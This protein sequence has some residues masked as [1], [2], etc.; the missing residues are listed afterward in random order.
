MPR[1]VYAGALAFL[2]RSGIP[3]VRLLGGEPTEHPDFGD[4]VSLALEGGFAVTVFTSGLI[5]DTALASLRAT[6]PGRVAVVMNVAVPK[7]DPNEW[8]TAQARVCR[9]L[10]AR[11]ELGL[12][13]APGA[14]DPSFLL[15][16]IEERGLRR[17]IRLGLA[18]P[19]LGAQ[20]AHLR[21]RSLRN[22]SR[23]LEPFVAQAIE[24]GV[25]VDFDCGFTCCMFSPHF[26]EDHPQ[27]A[28]DIGV[29]CNPIIDLL[30][31][32]KAIACYA[33][34]RWRHLP[35]DNRSTCDGL[36]R[37]FEQD[38]ED[39]L[40]VGM[41]PECATCAH[42]AEGRCNGGCRARRFRRL[43]PEPFQMP[44]PE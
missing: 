26:L 39:A 34:S 25:A 22:L 33:M 16:W 20:N 19:I 4:Y 42:F 29:R 5:P 44:G 24:V 36:V 6:P 31:E 13:L 15:P 23:V 35:V 10:G 1:D 3:D 43:R 9:D 32:G 18:H 21:T 38:W 8:V 41:Y 30:P 12:T 28:P 37:R 11:V 17:R 27:L 40:P 2:R 7:K 14:Q